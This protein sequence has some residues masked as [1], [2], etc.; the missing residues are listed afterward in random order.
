MSRRDSRFTRL[1]RDKMYGG[2][3]EVIERAAREAGVTYYQMAW[4][5]SHLVEQLVNVTCER[6][7]VGIPGFGQFF[8]VAKRAAGAGRGRRVSRLK[9]VPY[10]SLTAEVEARVCPDDLN[11]PVYKRAQCNSSAR[12]NTPIMSSAVILKAR[13]Q[14]IHDAGKDMQSYLL[15]PTGKVPKK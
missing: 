3:V 2:S 5:F 12:T 8:V 11:L 6:R 15:P 13:L 7:Q 4:A 10:Q 14:I 1:N 9:F